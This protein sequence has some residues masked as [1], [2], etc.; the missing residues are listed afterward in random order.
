VNR[1]R[2]PFLPFALEVGPLARLGR[3]NGLG[4][5]VLLDLTHDPGF[6]AVGPRYRRWLDRSITLDLGASVPVTSNRQGGVLLRAGLS[7]ADLV[8]VTARLEIDKRGRTAWGI[9]GELESK[10]GVIA[11]AICAVA[12]GVGLLLFLGGGRIG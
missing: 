6:L 12:A 10:A 5:T 9:G 7:Y 2:E 1:S 3:K 8:G 11:T 4:A